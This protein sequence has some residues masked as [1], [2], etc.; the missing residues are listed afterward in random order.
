[1]D[2]ENRENVMS[3]TLFLAIEETL[4]GSKKK[5]LSI[6]RHIRM[7]TVSL[8]DLPDTKKEKNL[9]EISDREG[10]FPFLHDDHAI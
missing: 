5:V 9:F 7:S 10:D 4:P 8:I 3:H 1:M 6:V 2:R